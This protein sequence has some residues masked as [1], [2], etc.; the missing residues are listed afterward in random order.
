MAARQ[1]MRLVVGS[2]LISRKGQMVRVPFSS[3]HGT[4]QGVLVTIPVSPASNNAFCKVGQTCQLTIG[5]QAYQLVSKRQIISLSPLFSSAF[6]FSFLAFF[7]E[8]SLFPSE[9][10]DRKGSSQSASNLRGQKLSE[11]KAILPE[12]SGN[13]VSSEGN[14]DYYFYL[15]LKSN[16]N[17]QSKSHS[18]K[19][20]K[21][22]LQKK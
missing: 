22:R 8:L 19:D 21:I 2:L 18:N 15:Q 10:L 13:N 11:E 17:E 5:R 16:I 7:K 4:G 20:C 3:M 14:L 9:D 12:A 1:P 6:L